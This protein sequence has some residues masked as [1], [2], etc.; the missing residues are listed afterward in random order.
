MG[1]SVESIAEIV[2]DIADQAGI[3]GDSR[4]L[5]TE[6]GIVHV[7]DCGCRQAWVPAIERRL[8]QAFAA[9]TKITGVWICEGRAPAPRHE[10]SVPYPQQCPICGTKPVGAP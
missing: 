5:P 8:R 3:Y 2:E 1:G 6:N 10:L 9:E 7:D 4:C